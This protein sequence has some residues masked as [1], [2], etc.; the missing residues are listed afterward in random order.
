[1]Q[2]KYSKI[3]WHEGVSR[4]AVAPHAVDQGRVAR[5]IRRALAILD[6]V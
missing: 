4:E 5:D 3:L 6:S 2:P 1:M